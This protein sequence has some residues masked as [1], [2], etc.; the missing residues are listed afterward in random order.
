LATLERHDIEYRKQL[1][2]GGRVIQVLFEDPN[3]V[4]IELGFD[5][6]TE[7]VTAENFDGIIM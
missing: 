3:G 4:V 7:S 2:G 1:V 5:P 6:E